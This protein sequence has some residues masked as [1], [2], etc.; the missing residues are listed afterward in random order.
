MREVPFFNYPYLFESKKDK[1]VEIFKDVASRGAYILQKDLTQFELNLA[2][3]CNTKYAIG[4]ANGTDAIWLALEAA[5]IGEGDEVI[6][7]SHTYI[8]TAGAVAFVN[9]TPVPVECK[10]DWMIDPVAV[11]GAITAKTKAILPTQ[12]NGR[13]CDMDALRGI[14]EKYDLIIIEDAAQALG[15]RYNGEFAGTMGL[16]GTISFY[17]AKTLGSFGDAGA[18]LTNDKELYDK[19]RFA[20]DHGRNDDGEFIMWGYN[21]RMDNLQAAILNYKL[22]YYDDEIARRRELA[23]LYNDELCDVSQ[24]KLP[25]KPDANIKYFDVYQNYE[26]RAEKR[27]QL[28]EYLKENGI[29]TLI[30]WSGQPV[31]TLEKLGFNN[32]SLPFTDD[33]FEGCFMLPLNTSLSNEDVLY[34]CKKI[35]EF[36]K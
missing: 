30:Q 2:N 12:V 16:A 18:I 21:S 33:F 4:V 34:V 13:C 3:Y 24:I 29:G 5:G 10:D 22:T 23:S 31:H 20:R 9:A 7:S 25:Q 27:T 36:Y 1:F 28:R 8:A 32:I 17:P 15:A 6:L 26:I 35:K 14:A 11:E 19:M